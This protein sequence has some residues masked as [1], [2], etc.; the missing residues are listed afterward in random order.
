MDEY[1][2]EWDLIPFPRRSV[3]SRAWVAADIYQPLERRLSEVG[4]GCCLGPSIHPT[5][6]EYPLWARPKEH[7]L[8][9]YISWAQQIFIKHPLCAR[10][11]KHLLSPFCLPDR[12][13]IYQAPTVC[14]ARKHLSST[15]CMLVVEDRAENITE[16]VRSREGVEFLQNQ[17]S[18]AVFGWDRMSGKLSRACIYTANAAS[19]VI[20]DVGEPSRHA[21]V[22]H[23]FCLCPCPQGYK[24]FG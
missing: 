16:K 4:Q 7:L 10:L 5:F 11:R 1:I 19:P 8:S 24:E 9:T 23:W 21:P 12:K 6:T 3:L 20:Q 2:G 14:R 18:G 22:S 15:Y 17:G 13:S